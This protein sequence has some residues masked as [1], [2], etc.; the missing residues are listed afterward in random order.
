MRWRDQP[1]AGRA[2]PW[3]WAV[4][5]A[6][7]G[8]GHLADTQAG[9]VWTR[10]DQV[11]QGTLRVE[12]QSLVI[13]A[14]AGDP[15]RLPLSRLR[16]AVF[17][18][19][20]P[21]TTAP[22]RGLSHSVPPGEPD[23]LL[24]S[25][26]EGDQPLSAWRRVRSGSTVGPWAAE[27]AAGVLKLDYAG[28]D[29]RQGLDA[30]GALTH[31]VTGDFV[32][33]ACLTHLELRGSEAEPQAGLLIQA[34]A[35]P[36]SPRA[37]FVMDSAERLWRFTRTRGGAAVEVSQDKLSL[38]QW[39]RVVRDGK[40]VRCYTSGDGARWELEDLLGMQ[41]PTEAEVGFVA[42]TPGLESPAS[43]RFEHIRLTRGLPPL[44]SAVNGVWLVN[45]TFLATPT[46]DLASLQ[47]AD[48][49][50]TVRW[51]PSPRTL[52]LTESQVARILYQPLSTQDANQFRGRA[53][54]LLAN[55]DFS[56]GAVRAVRQGEITVESILLGRHSHR[57]QTEAACI[58]FREPAPVDTPLVVTTKDGA[59][60]A[61]QSLQGRGELVEL[62]EPLLGWLKLPQNAIE[63]IWSG[64]APEGAG[65]PARPP[66]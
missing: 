27:F 45:G 51:Q 56:E 54:V 21:M 22:T 60:L 4:G 8:A 52:A 7:G 63:A 50:L 38:P 17:T 43:A 6:V 20:E 11:H 5:V 14:A 61:A 9:T 33:S 13:Q 29:L 57:A 15:L 35:Q 18:D 25:E 48:G 28:G 55:G 44:E 34:D 32:L 37:A 53:G 46:L 19:A 39:L 24:P 40:S 12:G 10:D 58:V 66:R 1:G 59:R 41:L 31:R 2:W 36:G 65:N 16:R 64:T 49:W 3:V 23:L 62:E 30:F 26:I 47:L 42:S